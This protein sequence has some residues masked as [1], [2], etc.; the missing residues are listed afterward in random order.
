MIG[1]ELERIISN[2]GAHVLKEL[3]PKVI[4]VLELLEQLT[5]RKERDTEQLN[6]CRLRI[7]SL[8]MEKMSRFHEREKYEKVSPH[9][10]HYIIIIICLYIND[11]TF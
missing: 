5:L 9:F 1:S 2:Y 7:S 4:N 11:F 10:S 6:E 8:E 3:M